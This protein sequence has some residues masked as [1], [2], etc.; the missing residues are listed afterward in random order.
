MG[1]MNQ[2]VGKNYDAEKSGRIACDRKHQ[3]TENATDA[4]GSHEEL[5]DRSGKS[6]CGDT[7]QYLNESF[8]ENFEDQT[9]QAS[10]EVFH[11]LS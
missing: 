10:K 5:A 4:A 7:Q 8:G 3:C 11:S 2:R 9:E 6:I 1:W